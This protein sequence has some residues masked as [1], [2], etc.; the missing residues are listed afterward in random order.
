MET[1]Q[2]KPTIVEQTTNITEYKPLVGREEYDISKHPTIEANI[3]ARL[4][5]GRMN[6]YLSASL[7]ARLRTNSAVS[8]RGM[9][10]ADRPRSAYF[11]ELDGKLIVEW[12]EIDP[13]GEGKLHDYLNREVDYNDRVKNG[14][15]V[16]SGHLGFIRI[17]HSHTRARVGLIDS[18]SKED[19]VTSKSSE[20]R[21]VVSMMNNG[22]IPVTSDGHPVIVREEDPITQANEPTLIGADLYK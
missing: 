13:N 10:G 22:I 17:P 7:S 18:L 8:G 19:V 21:I 20:F 14:G 9:F 12:G 5:A 16:R 2:R 3:L 4:F 15:T 1:L 11:T 6:D